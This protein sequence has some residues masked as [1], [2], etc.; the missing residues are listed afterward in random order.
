MINELEN[1]WKEAVRIYL[2]V[3]AGIRMEGL[4]EITKNLSE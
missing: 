1:T 3:P 4:R 2:K